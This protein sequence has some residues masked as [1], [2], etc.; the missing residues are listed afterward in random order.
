MEGFVIPKVFSELLA[1]FARDC[2]SEEDWEEIRDF[3]FNLLREKGLLREV[4]MKDVYEEGGD[5]IA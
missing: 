3:T 4:D 5:G 2:D 1:S